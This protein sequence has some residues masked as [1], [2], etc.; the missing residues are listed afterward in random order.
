MTA[1]AGFGD[2][3]LAVV[4]LEEER[5]VAA[6][7]MRGLGRFI[8]Q[9]KVGALG[10][11]MALIFLVL[12]AAGPHI[13]PYDK[14]ETFSNANPNYE[15]GSTDPEKI[16][17]TT[18]LRLAGPSWE[19]PLGTDDKGRDLL[20]RVLVGARRALYF[21]F[22]SA[23]MAT[24][25]GAIIG[26]ASG[27]FGGL[28]DLVLQRL[29][30]AMIAIPGL[31]FLLLLIQIGEV[32]LF[33]VILA[34]SILGSFGAAR[35]VRSAALSTR[36]EVYVEA[37]RVVGAS[38][39]RIVARHLLPNI[40]APIIVIFSISIGTAI[41]A[42]AGLSFLNLGAPGPSWGKMVAQGRLTFDSQPVM[43]I[44]GGG[45]ITFTVA[46]FNLLGDAMRDVLDPRQRGT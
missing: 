24:V 30:D 2:Q 36:N 13:T 44:V 21:G 10:L 34:L 18:L 23:A 26:V 1:G 45:A 33:R 6:R 35:V 9:K 3:E 20:T 15:R 40:A 28:V 43:S 22:A 31:I 37:A 16:S 12:G 32:T 46:A 41:L 19:H 8:R 4:A 39:L 29:V 25:L 5:S 14:D 38:H 42:E 11:G 27:Y 17:P 7:A